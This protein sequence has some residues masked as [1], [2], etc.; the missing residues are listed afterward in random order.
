[1][2]IVLPAQNLGLA[3]GFYCLMEP[4]PWLWKVLVM[5]LATVL[6]LF[7]LLLTCGYEFRIPF[8]LDYWVAL[9]KLGFSIS[10][11]FL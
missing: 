4:L 6:V 3:L 2:C 10:N 8:L 9:F 7:L 1:M 11:D 5:V